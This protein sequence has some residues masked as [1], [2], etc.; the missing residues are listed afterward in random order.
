MTSPASERYGLRPRL[1]TFTAMRPP[2]SSTRAALGE[3][4]AQHLEVLEVATRDAAL[5]ELGLV[6]LA[7]EVRR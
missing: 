4:V 6:L 2:G 1:A 3:H 7:G 5:A